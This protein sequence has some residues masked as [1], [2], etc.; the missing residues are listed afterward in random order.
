MSIRIAEQRDLPE[1]LAIYNHEVLNSVANLDL[2]PRTLDEWQVWFDLHNIEN[3]PLCVAE[4]DGRIAGYTSLSSYREKEA[5]RSTVELSIYVAPEFRKRGL[6]SE[7]MA[8][9]LDMARADERTHL[10]ISVISATNEPSIRLHE[11][12][13]FTYGGTIPEV[14]VKFGVY[15]D[16]VNYWLGV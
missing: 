15:Q 1:L 16:I 12:L 3:H 14:G 2:T 10:V 5:F 7:L 6:A 9:I 4:I 11:K 13:G 8:Y